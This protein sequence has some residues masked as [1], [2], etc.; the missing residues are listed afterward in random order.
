M[1]ESVDALDWQTWGPEAF[2]QAEAEQKPILLTVGAAWSFG[3]AEL[4]RTTYRDV[5]DRQLVERFFVP[6]WVDADDRPD[7][8]NAQALGAA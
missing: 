1:M 3:S 2:A 6:I 8:S 7:V 4:L 5:E